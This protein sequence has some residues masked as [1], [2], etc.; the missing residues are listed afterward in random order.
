MKRTLSN[1]PA[2]DFAAPEREAEQE[3]VPEEDMQ[4][5]GIDNIRSSETFD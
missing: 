2:E 1:L 5:F 4:P 3:G